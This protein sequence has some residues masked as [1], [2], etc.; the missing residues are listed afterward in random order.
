MTGKGAADVTGNQSRRFATM[1]DAVRLRILHTLLANLHDAGD[2]RAGA[3]FGLSLLMPSGIEW[4]ELASL[5]TRNEQ[6]KQTPND[7]AT[8]FNDWLDSEGKR[9]KAIVDALKQGRVLNGS[10]RQY[11]EVKKRVKLALDELAVRHFQYVPLPLQR[12]TP[13]RQHWRGVSQ[14][15]LYSLSLEFVRAVQSAAE[16]GSPGTPSW[17]GSAIRAVVVADFAFKWCVSCSSDE[18]IMLWRLLAVYVTLT[19]TRVALD[20][21]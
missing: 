14:S 20:A 3:P 18:A 4:K 11:S 16:D 13:A 12:Q 19:N 6:L 10:G 15:E 5:I 2:L 21:P 1:T 17:D 8:A 9:D 7:I